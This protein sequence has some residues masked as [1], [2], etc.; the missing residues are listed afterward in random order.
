MDAFERVYLSIFSSRVGDKTIPYGGFVSCLS[1]AYVF[2]KDHSFCNVT[3]SPLLN[4]ATQ[5]QDLPFTTQGLHRTDDMTLYIAC[6][7]GSDYIWAKGI[8][9]QSLNIHGINIGCIVFDLVEEHG[10]S[11]LVPPHAHKNDFFLRPPDTF[12]DNFKEQGML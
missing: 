7:F 11:R 1:K 3:V 12:L 5:R 8:A 4:I 6:P 9:E 10:F 2:G